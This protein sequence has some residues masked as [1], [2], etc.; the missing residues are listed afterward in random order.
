MGSIIAL[1]TVETLTRITVVGTV[2]VETATIRS[3]RDVLTDT[4]EATTRSTS[5]TPGSVRSVGGRQ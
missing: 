1:A 5:S 2:T 4:R 3:A